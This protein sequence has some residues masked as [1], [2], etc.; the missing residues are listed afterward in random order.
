MIDIDIAF[1]ELEKVARACERLNRVWNTW[2]HDASP[3]RE[4]DVVGQL[5]VVEQRLAAFK[6][7]LARHDKAEPDASR[8][9]R[10]MMASL[11]AT[12]AYLERDG[13]ITPS[14]KITPE[15][16]DVVFTLA[17]EML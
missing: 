8:E 15:M 7:V 10:V 16:L 13:I 4:A 3:A 6:E 2:R 14:V 17:K 9:E 1:P 11:A 5:K 12:M